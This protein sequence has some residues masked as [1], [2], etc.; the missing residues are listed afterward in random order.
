[1]KPLKFFSLVV[2]LFLLAG[3]A[4]AITPCGTSGMTV[5]KADSGGRYVVYAFRE[6]P[7]VAFQVPGTDMS[8]PNGTTGSKMFTLDGVVFETL[9]VKTADFI[10]P[11]TGKSDL[12]ILK[13]HRDF[14][15]A[16]IQKA[17][18]AL[19]KMVELGPRDRP[20]S[21]GQ[22][23]FTFYL[24]QMI[25]PKKPRGAS[26]YFLTTVTSGEVAVLSA[27]V[28][29]E[30]KLDVA[31]TAFESYASSFQHILRKTQCPDP[32]KKS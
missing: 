26:Q 4:W 3:H 7:D 5:V 27:I 11:T 28:P 24:W 21:N 8:F 12:E 2:G 30:A 6:G 9:F 31:M 29:D 19:Q 22:P 16:F 14:D 25:D 18:G 10:K 20:A 15:V 32:T 17:G 1:M 13:E 23:A